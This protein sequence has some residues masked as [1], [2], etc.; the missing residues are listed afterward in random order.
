[1]H[2]DLFPP[3]CSH[4]T[5]HQNHDRESKTQ[6]FWWRLSESDSASLTGTH[7]WLMGFWTP[8]SSSKSK[9]KCLV[10]ALQITPSALCD[11]R[12]V[13]PC[14]ACPSPQT[15]QRYIG[16][17]FPAGNMLVFSPDLSSLFSSPCRTETGR[18][19]CRYR[20]RPCNHFNSSKKCWLFGHSIF[21]L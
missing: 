6:W 4:W 1:M 15:N 2:G 12:S 16:Q 10:L 8:L 14:L 21:P 20:P 18:G 9:E 17:D 13:A 11:F 3:P 5:Y 7:I 19:C